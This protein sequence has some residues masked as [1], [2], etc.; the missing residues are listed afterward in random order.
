MYCIVFVVFIICVNCEGVVMDVLFYRVYKR[1]D[2]EKYCLCKLFFIWKI[3]VCCE[4][5]VW[6][7]IMYLLL[8]VYEYFYMN[9]VI[10]W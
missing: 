5:F 7:V 9:Y 1:S 2:N 4:I 8:I 3:N 10:W 6:M